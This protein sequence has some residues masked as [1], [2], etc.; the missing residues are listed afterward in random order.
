MNKKVWPYETLCIQI[1]YQG[2]ENYV[3]ISIRIRH[4]FE[5][6]SLIQSEEETQQKL[7]M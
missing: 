1:G 7:Q 6:R 5:T 4:L 2:L 3:I